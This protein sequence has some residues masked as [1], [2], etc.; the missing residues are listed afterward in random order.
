MQTQN[1]APIECTDWPRN[2]LAPNRSEKVTPIGSKRSDPVRGAR[3]LF[4]LYEIGK[5]RPLI[6][7]REISKDTKS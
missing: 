4:R 3:P 2:E 1:C 6:F 5:L 7:R